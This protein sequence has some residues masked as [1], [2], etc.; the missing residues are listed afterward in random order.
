MISI[1]NGEVYRVLE[2]NKA[3]TAQRRR[4]ATQDQLHDLRTIEHRVCSNAIAHV[5]AWHGMAW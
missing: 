2:A 4:T 5:V 1:T 3:N